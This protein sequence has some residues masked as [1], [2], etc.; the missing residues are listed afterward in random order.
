M[1]PIV[2][3]LYLCLLESEHPLRR[4]FKDWVGFGGREFLDAE[5]EAM[6][7]GKTIGARREHIY[8]QEQDWALMSGQTIQ[9]FLLKYD[10]MTWRAFKNA[11]DKKDASY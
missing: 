7:F 4:A 3:V 10:N 1:D 11:E 6:S 9:N 8:Q 2:Y 5:L